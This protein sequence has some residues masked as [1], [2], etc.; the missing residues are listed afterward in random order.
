MLIQFLNRFGH[1]FSNIRAVY[2][3]PYQACDNERL[4]IE[5]ISFFVR[6]LLHGNEDKP[7]LCEPRQYQEHEDDFSDCHLFSFVAWD[8]VSWPGNDFYVGSRATDDGVKAAAT[9]SMAVMTG[10]EGSY[11][12]ETYKYDPPADYGSWDNVVR[13]NR[14][15]IRVD[16]NL[17]VMV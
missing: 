9:N 1:R 16:D 5:H 15:R 14:I 6:P 17:S 4:E 13:E 2:Y 8:H 10:I 12:A 3:D 7:Q 11:N